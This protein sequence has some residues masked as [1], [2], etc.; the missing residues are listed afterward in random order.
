[1]RIVQIQPEGEAEMPKCEVIF[2][3]VLS[4]SVKQVDQSLFSAFH[5]S[6]LFS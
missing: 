3:R 6:A 1:M 4:Y 2:E 5:A